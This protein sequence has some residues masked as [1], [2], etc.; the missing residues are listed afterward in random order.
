MVGVNLGIRGVEGETF[1]WIDEVFIKERKN[2][3]GVGGDRDVCWEWTG[4]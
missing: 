4:V 1:I 2:I 3:G